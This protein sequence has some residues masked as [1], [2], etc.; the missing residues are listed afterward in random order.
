MVRRKL[1]LSIVGCCLLL[2]TATPGPAVAQEEGVEELMR[3]TV[4]ALPVAPT[5]IELARLTLQPGG[6]RELV[7]PGTELYVVETGTPG[8]RVDGLA[9]LT[10][11]PVDGV[12]TPPETMTEGVD[13][14]LA[15][16][17]QVL[18]YAN[19]PHALLN[20]GGDAAALI[21]LVIFP[22]SSLLPGWLPDEV[23]PTG[24]GV[25]P[26]AADVVDDPDSLPN[27]PVVVSL[28]RVVVAGD[29]ATP[30]ASPVAPFDTLHDHA[31][32]AA[33]GAT[34][35]DNL[36]GRFALVIVEQGVLA[37]ER[38]AATGETFRQGESVRL[39]P[40]APA[41]LR[42][43]SEAVLVALALTIDAVEPAA[44]DGTPADPAA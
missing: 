30:E 1:V 42:N 36:G 35:L 15:V 41:V 23:S 13:F 5:A 26:L 10:R 18:V 39:A 16:G 7:V 17:D 12:D 14:T 9:T 27:A 37:V 8:I 33:E 44:D 32:P 43:G 20:D 4:D 11:A 24:V 3:A 34:A 31:T 6:G 29:A 19:V 40:G 21:N 22:A 38:N 2:A 28:L 25:V